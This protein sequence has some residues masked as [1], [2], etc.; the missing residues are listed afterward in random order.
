M[1]PVAVVLFVLEVIAG[2]VNLRQL[3]LEL[4]REPLEQGFILG[5][6][7][8]RGEL[9]QIDRDRNQGIAHGP[10]PSGRPNAEASSIAI[11]ALRICQ[12]PSF[13]LPTGG[14]GSFFTLIVIVVGVG[15]ALAALLIFRTI[16][17]RAKVA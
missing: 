6:H 13:A 3:G 15:L 7:H 16:R 4:F 11:L 17:K 10:P 12:P 8:R 14:S 2:V 9:T 1:R 5:A